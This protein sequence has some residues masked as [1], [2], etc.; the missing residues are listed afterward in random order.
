MVRQASRTVDD[1]LKVWKDV[2]EVGLSSLRTISPWIEFQGKDDEH[3]LFYAFQRAGALTVV[4]RGPG[5]LHCF[6]ARGPEGAALLKRLGSAT[7][8]GNTA[9]AIR[10]LGIDPAATM[11]L[12]FELY[13]KGELKLAQSPDKTFLFKTRDLRKREIESIVSDIDDKVQK[14]LSGFDSFV[15]LIE[16][17]LD[18]SR[19]LKERFGVPPLDD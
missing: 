10:K 16:A 17:G 9:A 13:D 7:S 2:C 19:A 11:E 1:V 14:R 5:R 6:E 3:A 15:Q 12:L 8:I 18:P 4:A